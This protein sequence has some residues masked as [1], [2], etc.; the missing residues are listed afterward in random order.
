M[1]YDSINNRHQY[2]N[3]REKQITIFIYINIH[4]LYIHCVSFFIKI[5]IDKFTIL[6]IDRKII[7]I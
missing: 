4:I 6:Q 7:K 1:I 3:V 2:L 5:I